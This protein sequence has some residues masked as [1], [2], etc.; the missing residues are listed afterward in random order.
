MIEL[1]SQIMKN[2]NGMC[3]C[4]SRKIA[5]DYVFFF[6][7]FSVPPHRFGII[8]IRV[9]RNLR[10]NLIRQNGLKRLRDAYGVEGERANTPK[11]G[12]SSEFHQ[13]SDYV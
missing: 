4:H 13:P 8:Y 1:G 10:K 2:D 11:Q 9:G 12:F 5:F 6:C 3:T 7:N